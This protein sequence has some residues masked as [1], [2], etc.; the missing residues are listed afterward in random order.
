MDHENIA[1]P[2][3]SRDLVKVTEHSLYV[4]KINFML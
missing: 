3:T 4:Q 2:K 1:G